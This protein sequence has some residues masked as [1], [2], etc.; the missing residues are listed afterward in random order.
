MNVLF[1]VLLT[2]LIELIEQQKEPL[3]GMFCSSLTKLETL[4]SQG[5]WNENCVGIIYMKASGKKKQRR[6]GNGK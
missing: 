1:L 5:C 2:Y 6:K 4:K 3:E